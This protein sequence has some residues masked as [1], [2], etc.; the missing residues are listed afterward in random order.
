VQPTEQLRSQSELFWVEKERLWKESEDMLEDLPSLD[1]GE[2][3]YRPKMVNIDEYE[4]YTHKN[5]LISEETLIFTNIENQGGICTLVIP[6]EY[7]VLLSEMGGTTFVNDVQTTG[8]ASSDYGNFTVSLY[9]EK[10]LTGEIRVE[11]EKRKE[12]AEA[13]TFN[14]LLITMRKLENDP[15]NWPELQARWEESKTAMKDLPSLDCGKLG[16]F[17]PYMSDVDEY[18]YSSMNIPLNDLRIQGGTCTLIVPND[19][20]VEWR[21]IGGVIFIDGFLLGLGTDDGNI[22]T[23]YGESRLTG[24]IRAQWDPYQPMFC[25][26]VH[27]T[28]R[29]QESSQ[30]ILPLMERMEN[31]RKAEEIGFHLPWLICGEGRG[32]SESFKNFPQMSDIDI[33]VYHY[34]SLERLHR[35][36]FLTL[37]DLR[38]LGSPCTLIVP[39]GYYILLSQR[40]G[41]AFVNGVQATNLSSDD[42]VSLYGEKRLTGEIRVEWKPNELNSSTDFDITMQKLENEPPNW[43]ELQAKWED[44]RKAMGDLPLLNCGKFGSFGPTMVGIGTYEYLIHDDYRIGS[45]ISREDFR[46]HGGTCQYIVPNGYYVEWDQFS[47]TVFINDRQTIPNPPMTWIKSDLLPSMQ[48]LPNR[49]TKLYG[50]EHLI[51]TIIAEW[52][53]D[54]EYGG[55]LHITLFKQDN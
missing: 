23:L 29:K 41:T 12:G 18:R 53:P 54:L 27:I 48:V 50:V 24:E 5:Y 51:G 13:S 6:D 8:R 47:G 34:P 7:Y 11:W 55:F 20:Y 52:E 19:Y 22:T 4:Y 35:V 43:P 40:G 10:R 44:S 17:N 14:Q 46:Q 49:P 38:I 25:P 36:Q 30:T 3:V 1:C 21:Q 31:W 16:V 32:K 26:R 45:E 33:G 15:P 9:G 28:V 39:D 2:W 37:D 42:Y